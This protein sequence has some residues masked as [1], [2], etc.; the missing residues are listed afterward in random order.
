MS[1][2]DLPRAMRHARQLFE[3]SKRRGEKRTYQ[4]CINEA[5]ASE[6]ERQ[7]LAQADEDFFKTLSPDTNRKEP[8]PCQ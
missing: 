8:P 5:V 1:T 7:Q 3:E 6:R 4:G 2:F